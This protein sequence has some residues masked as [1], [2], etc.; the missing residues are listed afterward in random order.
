MFMSRWKLTLS[1]LARMYSED[2]GQEH[3][4]VLIQLAGFPV[5]ASR[6]RKEMERLRNSQGKDLIIEV[7]C[8]VDL[9]VCLHL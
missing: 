8:S 3:G 1:V 5:K 4:S 2:V 9:Q 7:Y 6:F